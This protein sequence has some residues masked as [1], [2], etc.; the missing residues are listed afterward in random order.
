MKRVAWF[1]AFGGLIIAAFLTVIRS[2]GYAASTG[3]TAQD[4][5]GK[6][7]NNADK[8]LKLQMTVEHEASSTGGIPSPPVAR[9]RYVFE[10][11]RQR[12][13]IT[14]LAPVSG[15]E[16][17]IDIPQDLFITRTPNGSVGAGISGELGI[18]RRWQRTGGRTGWWWLWDL[19]C[20]QHGIW[21]PAWRWDGWCSSI[22]RSRV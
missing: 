9:E 6:V 12:V 16:W 4:L 13:K 2:Q 15:I 11:K 20:C 21:F 3:L 7:Q 22:R 1:H 17:L 5:L 8:I 19:Q 18:C 14:Y 10:P